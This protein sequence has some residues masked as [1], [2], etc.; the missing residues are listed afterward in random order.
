MPLRFFTY[1]LP[2][3]A[4]VAPL[5]ADAQTPDTTTPPTL[6]LDV[7]SRL[8]LEDIL[9]FD[10]AGHPVFDLPQAAFHVTDN[11]Q[12]ETIR[13]FEETSPSTAGPVA[14][15]NPLPVG[16]FRN[17]S[18][19]DDHT[20]SQ[21]LLIDADS[22]GIEDQMYLL[23]QLQKSI[24]TLPPGLQTAV[25]LVHSGRVVQIRGFGT[26]RA[27]LRRALHECLPTLG[28]VAYDQF[29][30]AVNQLL[31]VS[32]YLEQTPGRKNILWLA[33]AFPLVSLS[34]AEA[35]GPGVRPDYVARERLIH[36]LQE[37]L[38]EARV[39]V[40]PV[41]VRGVIPFSIPNPAGQASTPI[42]TQGAA[43]GPSPA[44]TSGIT[45]T[46]TVFGPAADGV[47]AQ[48]SAMRELADATGGRAYTLNFLDREITEAF[49]LGLRAYTLSFSPSGY[50]NDE[51]WHR[52]RIS[53][54]PQP[55]GAPGPYTLSYRPGYL[56]T[57]TG[58]AG[59]RVGMRLTAEG[60]KVPTGGAHTLSAAAPLPFEVHIEPGTPARKGNL[61]VTLRFT[62]PVDQLDFKRQ[63][64]AWHNQ[65]VIAS[66]VYNAEG[67][68]K[69]G[70][71]QQFTTTLSD[72]KWAGARG[73]H[74]PLTQTLDVPRNADYLM[75]EMRDSGNHRAGSLMLSLRAVRSL[76]G[77][78]AAGP[79][80]SPSLGPQPTKPPQPASP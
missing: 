20:A 27:D 26:D 64:E 49:Q 21:V 42:P 45:S 14:P 23:Q 70:H 18:N 19:G 22:M 54:E 30:S 57:W 37:A 1:A 34:A 55:G 50:T 32:A 10:R 8:V 12:P 40:Y 33:G 47:F 68:I 53:V 58:V 31:T 52:V 15:A 24:A 38:A 43:A 74:L 17:T 63:G 77:P 4:L 25:F 80:P 28:A 7:S 59:G 65:I 41:D 51:S 39:S 36:Q 29:D 62:I 9:V 75:L 69:G 61:P 11:G 72:A 66:Y 73:K 16:T 6:T 67:R 35:N 3:L 48:R 78:A 56:A 60:G 79:T 5:P 44:L 71:M 76:P 2:L 46:P 13:S